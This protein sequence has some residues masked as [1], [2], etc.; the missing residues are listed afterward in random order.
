MYSLSF[1]ASTS[2]FTAFA[3]F[4]GLKHTL[5]QSWLF[6]FFFVVFSFSCWSYISAAAWRF[7]TLGAARFPSTKLRRPINLT[8]CRVKIFDS[9]QAPAAR[10]SV[11]SVRLLPAQSWSKRAWERESGRESFCGWKF[12]SER[13]SASGGMPLI[14]VQLASLITGPCQIARILPQAHKVN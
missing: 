9:Q 7:S 3:P 11:S 13:M 8:D 4:N 10:T 14:T 2:S 6:P 5:P 12:M 1:S